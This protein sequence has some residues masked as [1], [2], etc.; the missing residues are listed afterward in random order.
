MLGISFDVPAD[1]KAFRDKFDF[2]FSL[3]SD[4][5][6]SV[7][8]Q[9]DAL[10]PPDDDFANFS[11]RISYLIDPEGSIVKAYEV[12]DPAGHADMVLAD[13]RAR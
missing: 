6:K 10:R 1:N 3:L 5:D 12:E 9:Y 7:G 8:A 4:P 2:P 13:L 11:K